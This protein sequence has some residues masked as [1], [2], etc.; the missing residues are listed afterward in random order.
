MQGEFIIGA[1]IAIGTTVALCSLIRKLVS[2]GRCELVSADWLSRFSVAKYRPM[3]RILSAADFRFLNAQK[4]YRP[5]VARRLR[6]ER[7]RAY[8]GYLKCLRADYRKLE[9]AVTLWMAHSPKDRP[10][11]AIELLKRR[12][13]FFLAMAAAEG[14]LV[15]FG[16]NITPPMHL[17]LVDDLDDL[18]VCLRRVA[19][20]RQASLS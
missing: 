3:E 20:V 17:R 2:P 11:M 15:L 4:G 19:M 1:V 6:W 13:R 18:R 14:R 10:E 9:A 8:R 16:L 7:I 12:I 5:K